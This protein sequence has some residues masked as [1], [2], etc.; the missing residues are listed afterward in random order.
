MALDPRIGGPRERGLH[1]PVAQC[2]DV[3]DPSGT[4]GLVAMVEVVPV[5]G[6]PRDCTCRPVSRISRCCR[7]NLASMATSCSGLMRYSSELEDIDDPVEASMSVENC[8]SGT[9]QMGVP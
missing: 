9:Y 8:S 6:R 1:D 5:D 4:F 7:G 2:V 3:L